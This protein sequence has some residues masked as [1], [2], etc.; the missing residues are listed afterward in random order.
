MKYILENIIIVTPI[1]ENDEFIDLILSMYKRLKYPHNFIKIFFL[2]NNMYFKGQNDD[3]DYGKYTY[4]KLMDFKKWNDYVPEFK[5]VE[6]EY[7]D[8][9]KL[10]YPYDKSKCS[11]FSG[12]E[13]SQVDKAE[14]RKEV[15]IPVFNK[16]F[17]QYVKADSLFFI[18]ADYLIRDQ[19]L[20]HKLNNALEN[21]ETD[22]SII[23]DLFI[24]IGIGQNHPNPSRRVKTFFYDE[25]KGQKSIADIKPS[26]SSAE[27]IEF[28][29]VSGS[30]FF[31]F[32]DLLADKNIRFDA[33]YGERDFEF[34]FLD[35]LREDGWKFYGLINTL[36]LHLN[37][38]FFY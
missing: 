25:N 30:Y 10:K 11:G 19:Y 5:S 38:L 16:C 27:L 17:D 6:I 23:S 21:L 14:W 3:T 8:L 35:K 34:K 24:D 18:S 1:S 32:A 12:D 26:R 22:K 13:E 28:P 4:H 7:M 15:I 33:D 37:R 31:P 20:F 9:G 36:N 2:C 29:Y